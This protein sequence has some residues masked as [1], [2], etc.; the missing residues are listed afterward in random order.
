MPARIRSVDLLRGIA[1]LIV[2]AWHYQWYFGGKPFFW[3]LY[4]FYVNGQLAVDLFFVISG[5]V[6]MHVY[7]SKLGSGADLVNYIQ[8][9]LAR[10]YPLHVAT[11]LATALVFWGF[12]T[13]TG[14][15][16]FIYTANDPYHFVLNLLML[17]YVGIQ[18]GWSFNGPSWTI[19]SEF[20]INVIFGFLL[21]GARRHI[22]AAA[23][24]LVVG[25]AL[26]LLASGAW[27]NE[28]K[29]SHW[30][31]PI[32]LRTV[33]GFFAGVLTY[34]VWRRIYPA[35]GTLALTIGALA[36]LALMSYP[37]TGPY[38]LQAE[39]ALALAA[40]PALVYGCASSRLAEKAGETRVGR[41]LGEISFSVYMWHFPLAG[42]MVLVVGR[43]AVPHPVLLLL[44]TA[45][46]LAVATASV[47]L[48]EFPARRWVTES[49]ITRRRPLTLG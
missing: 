28:V 36:T 24:A 17:Q 42:L 6:L 33:A 5:F 18:S 15:Y 22:V 32:L 31:E 12:Q 49:R 48:F 38:L 30:L 34:I 4:P 29:I 23:A 16:G 39:A 19:S 45:S 43:D 10:L 47:K 44:Y 25:A 11:L 21:V 3:A 8:R 9:R 41:W 46:V 35:G 20:W 26:I 14:T 27:Y 37:R 13:A 1:A 40:A 7:G 2:V